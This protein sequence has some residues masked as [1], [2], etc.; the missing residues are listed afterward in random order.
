MSSIRMDYCIDSKM[1]S[2]PPVSFK[3]GCND[4]YMIEEYWQGF[5]CQGPSQGAFPLYKKGCTPA[6]NASQLGLLVECKGKVMP[7]EAPAQVSAHSNGQ[8]PSSSLATF[9]GAALEAINKFLLE[10]AA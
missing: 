8:L 6:A 5:A 4:T 9:N 3:W 7:A 2:G 1:S 10:L